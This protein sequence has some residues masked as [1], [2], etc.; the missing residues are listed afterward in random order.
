MRKNIFF[1]DDMKILL[2]IQVFLIG[3]KRL[4]TIEAYDGNGKLII[5]TNL[6]QSPQLHISR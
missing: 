6:K 5:L 3:L 1:T 2:T 4:F